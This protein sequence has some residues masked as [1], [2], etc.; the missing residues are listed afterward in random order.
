MEGSI[1]QNL[2][3]LP[4]KVKRMKSFWKKKKIHVVIPTPFATFIHSLLSFA[5]MFYVSFKHIVLLNTA[6][7]VFT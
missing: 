4:N 3:L 7:D 1:F 2:K 6:F 5:Q